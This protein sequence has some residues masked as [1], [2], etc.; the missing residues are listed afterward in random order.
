MID[1][2]DNNYRDYFR[3]CHTRTINDGRMIDV[4]DI[5]MEIIS[6]AAIHEQCGNPCSLHI[7]I[8][9]RD[10]RFRGHIAKL[11]TVQVE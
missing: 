4:N 8:F 1:V 2:N 7:L 5:T 11:P 10:N 6:L 9:P 3:D